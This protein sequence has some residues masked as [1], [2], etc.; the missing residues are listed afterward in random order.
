MDKSETHVRVQK[1]GVEDWISKRVIEKLVNGIEDVK[2]QGWQIMPVEPIEIQELRSKKSEEIE[3]APEMD[4]EPL[5]TKRK[6][7]KREN[8]E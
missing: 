6:Y 8:K 3:K 2:K 7:T 4:I 1:N 5:K